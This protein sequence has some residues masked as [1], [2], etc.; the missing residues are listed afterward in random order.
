MEGLAADSPLR[1]LPKASGYDYVVDTLCSAGIAMPGPVPLSYMEI[2]AWSELAGVE[3]TPWEAETIR[4]MSDCYVGQ[5]GKSRDPGALPPHDE[6]SMEQV[7][8][9][10]SSQF[11]RLFVKF[12]GKKRG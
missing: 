3:L 9:Q 4:Y 5:L 12:G 10:S 8:R 1:R 7:R 11:Q 2:R 6:R